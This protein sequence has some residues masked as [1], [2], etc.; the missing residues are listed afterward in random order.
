MFA[1]LQGLALSGF[2][3]KEAEQLQRNM[4]RYV[5]DGIT[6]AFPYKDEKT[7]Q[8]HVFDLT[9]ML[10]WGNLWTVGKHLSHGNI[11]KAGGEFGLASGPEPSLLYAIMSNRDLRSGSP[12]IDEFEKNDP[13]LASMAIMNYGLKLVMPSMFTLD[14]A[15]GRMWEHAEY[16]LSRRGQPTRWFN[17][18][19]RAFGINIHPVDPMAHNL[20]KLTETRKII[21]DFRSG[22]ITDALQ[23]NYESVKE[24]QDILQDIFERKHKEWE[25]EEEE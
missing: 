20:E 13:K 18:Y 25:E 14:G 10:P 1:A 16:G 11:L 7:Q 6:L 23:G 15:F 4:P 21:K 19:P 17:A 22:A 3:Q 24:K 9:P 12:I 2:S 5:A 8:I